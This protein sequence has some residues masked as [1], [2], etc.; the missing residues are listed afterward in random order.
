MIT[1]EDYMRSYTLSPLAETPAERKRHRA[2]RS[3]IRVFWRDLLARVKKE[4]SPTRNRE[5]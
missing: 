1:P 2:I 5:A 4:M 3:S